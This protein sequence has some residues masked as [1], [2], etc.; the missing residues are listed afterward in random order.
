MRCRA[1]RHAFVLAALAVAGC[2][3]SESPSAP[4]GPQSASPVGT[5]WQLASLDGQKV[6]A[7]TT[8][9]A[10]FTS[11]SRVAGSA[12]CNRYMGHAEAAGGQLSVGNIASTLMA[13]E[14]DG[15]MAQESRYLTALQ[16]AAVYAV[17]G[18]EL[19]LGRSST[20][21]TLVFTAK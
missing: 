19:R 15:V 7:G 8:I 10:E 2:S 11:D 17:A 6:I 14:L 13:C 9:T 21:T 18:G 16:A 20:A 5:T 3:S 12:G 4:S 1:I